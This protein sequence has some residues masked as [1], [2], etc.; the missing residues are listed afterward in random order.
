MSRRFKL[1]TN[2]GFGPPMQA[3]YADAMLKQREVRDAK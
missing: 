1:I 3:G 2:G